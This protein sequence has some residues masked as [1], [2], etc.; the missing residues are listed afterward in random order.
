[1]E[2]AERLKQKVWG[3]T[4]NLL[5]PAVTKDSSGALSKAVEYA[6]DLCDR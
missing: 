1:M 4:Q 5:T 3:C 2:S 6:Y